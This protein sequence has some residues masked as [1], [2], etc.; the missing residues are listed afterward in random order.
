MGVQ[1]SS[2]GKGAR[3]RRHGLQGARTTTCPLSAGKCTG[4]GFRAASIASELAENE[5]DLRLTQLD[6]GSQDSGNLAKV[7]APVAEARILCP[8]SFPTSSI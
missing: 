4:A 8:S 5:L 7:L 2:E 1:E 6:L 3:N